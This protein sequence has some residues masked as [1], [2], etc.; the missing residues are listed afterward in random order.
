MSFCLFSI[1]KLIGDIIALNIVVFFH[2]EYVF[3][4]TLEIN[5]S[6]SLK[7]LCL[8][9]FNYPVNYSSLPSLPPQKTH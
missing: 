3:Q 1:N 7:F 2:V 8:F 6:V 9:V 5:I 4:I